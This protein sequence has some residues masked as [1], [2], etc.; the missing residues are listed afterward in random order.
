LKSIG[1]VF[2]SVGSKLVLLKMLS[3]TTATAYWFVWV[4]VKKTALKLGTR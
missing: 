3:W 2:A 1:D 4:V